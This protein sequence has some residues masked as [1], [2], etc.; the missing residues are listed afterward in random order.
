M[1][2]FMTLLILISIHCIPS[3]GADEMKPSEH[4]IIVTAE[5]GPFIFGRS[6]PL[7]VSYRN[8]GAHPWE[9]S[10]PT[11]SI[12]ANGVQKFPNLLPPDS[13]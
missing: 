5:P 8:Q 13:A 10:T 6:I 7:K 9:I 2:C 11:D 12:E 4:T 3:Y 1:R